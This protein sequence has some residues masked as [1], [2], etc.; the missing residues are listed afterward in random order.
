[1]DPVVIQKSEN[2]QDH[3]YTKKSHI[4]GLGVL[5]WELT[6]GL[7]PF[8]FKDSKHASTTLMLRIV[9]GKRE[10]PIPNTNAKFVELYQSNYNLLL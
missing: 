7:P 1:M 9:G 5:F 2:E 4:Y 6:S 8:N 10:K 3:L